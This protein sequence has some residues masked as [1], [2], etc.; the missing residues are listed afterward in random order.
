MPA[1]PQERATQ[2]HAADDAHCLPVWVPARSAP[3]RDYYPVWEEPIA[4]ER[5]LQTFHARAKKENVGYPLLNIC[6]K[7]S[8]GRH[9]LIDAPLDSP[10]RVSISLELAEDDQS[11]TDGHCLGYVH[12]RDLEE[13]LGALGR[14]LTLPAVKHPYQ[15]RD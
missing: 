13:I 7:L 6:L 4:F 9:A 3:V 5:V 15:W 2:R 14:T 8:S 1:S 10:H 11:R 12:R